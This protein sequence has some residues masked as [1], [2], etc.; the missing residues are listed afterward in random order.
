MCSFNLIAWM[1]RA[2][3]LVSVVHIH[4]GRAGKKVGSV[5]RLEGRGDVPDQLPN[6]DTFRQVSCEGF[7]DSTDKYKLAGSCGLKYGLG[8]EEISWF[9]IFLVSSSSVS[10][11]LGSPLW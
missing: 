7:Q 6:L 11:D 4:E 2:I 8:V 5:G 3:A 10:V 1:A 9:K